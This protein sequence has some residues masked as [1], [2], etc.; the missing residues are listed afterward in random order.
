MSAFSPSLRWATLTAVANEI[1][2]PNVFLNRLCYSNRQTVPTEDIELGRFDK[3]REIA[4]FVKKN[5]EAV[6]VTGHTE[7]FQTVSGPN[8]RIKKPFAPSELLFNRRPGTVVYAKANDVV[9]AA[10]AH[11]ARDMGVMADYIANAEE[12]LAALSIRGQILYTATDAEVYQ[13][14]FPR[15]AGHNIT[16]S[17]FWNDAD[18][19]LPKPLKDIHTVKRL[20]SDEVGMQVTDGICGTEASDALRILVE[21]GKITVLGMNG[22]NVDAGTMTFVS[23]FRDDGVIYLG[24]LAGVR[25]WEYGRSALLNGVATTMIRAKY[26]EFIATGAAADRVMYFAAIPDMKAFK[27]RLFQSERFA[28][29]WEEEDPSRM[30]ALIHSR[31]LPVPRRPGATVSMK[32]VSG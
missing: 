12:Y 23:Q 7:T 13:I 25:F 32:V 8:I 1:K 18:L 27:G 3:G 26:V 28:K 2:S 21:A 14:T 9:S 15:P 24:T 29:S 17:V 5:G 16:L 31:P 4:P 20:I 19:N 6:M 10:E 22:T 11:I 30:M